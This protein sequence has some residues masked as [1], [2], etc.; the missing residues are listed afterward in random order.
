M[1]SA[2]ST[3]A[4]SA[5]KACLNNNMLSLPSRLIVSPQLQESLT[6]QQL[7]KYGYAPWTR[8]SQNEPRVALRVEPTK[9]LKMLETVIQA[10]LSE[11]RV[12]THPHSMQ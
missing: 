6:K 5:V 10:H 3:A 7:G 9:N 8:G 12:H 2:I 1:G 4:D 11:D